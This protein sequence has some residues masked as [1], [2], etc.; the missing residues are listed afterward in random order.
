[1]AGEI[2]GPFILEAGTYLF[3]TAITAPASWVADTTVE[4]ITQSIIGKMNTLTADNTYGS[5]ESFASISIASALVPYVKDCI[6]VKLQGG[7]GFVYYGKESELVDGEWQYGTGASYPYTWYSATDNMKLRVVT[8][9]SAQSVAST[10]NTWF[11]ANATRVGKI[12]SGTYKFK[13]TLSAP[14]T[15]FDQ[16]IKFNSNGWPYLKMMWVATGNTPGLWYGDSFHAYDSTTT[17][18]HEDDVNNQIIT[19]TED[20]IVSYDFE[21]WFVANTSYT[22][23]AGTYKFIGSPAFSN[24]S[25]ETAYNFSFTSDNSDFTYVKYGETGSGRTG[26]MYNDTTVYVRNAWTDTAYQTITLSTA[27]TVSADFYKWAITDGNLI[28]KLFY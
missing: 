20:T 1:M 16:E 15:A 6:N 18:W 12:S 4:T 11:N 23:E 9:E 3:N 7:T 10:F 27:Q 25:E 24:L 21:T 13:D 26:F 19:V 5:E 17:S 2:Q 22:L 14:S 28:K 8:F